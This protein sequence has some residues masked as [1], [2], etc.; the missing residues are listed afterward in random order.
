[1]DGDW[2]PRH[3][4][5]I[6]ENQFLPFDMT[7]PLRLGRQFDLVMSLE[8][9]EHLPERHAKQFVDSLTG[10]GA[11]VLFAAAI[12]Q[13]GGAEHQNEQWPEYWAKLFLDNKY[14]VVDCIR[15]HIWNN[16]KIAY[17]YSQNILLFVR[18]D[19][20]NN[21]I[22][23]KH[24]FEQTYINML[25]LVH[26]RHYLTALDARNLTLKEILY[27]LPHV[28]SKSI[29]FRIQKLLKYFNSQSPLS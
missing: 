17:W 4:L 26:P 1:V 10:A 27:L 2:V 23:L 18:K 9:A 3:L 24:E 5:K 28:L 6:P 19:F 29:A 11:V 22:L 15:K 20:L 25:S 16:D 14:E 21:N 13:Q 12:P 7:R 8:V